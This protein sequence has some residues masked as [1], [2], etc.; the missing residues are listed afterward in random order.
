MLSSFIFCVF[1]AMFFLPCVGLLVVEFP[2]IA[3]YCPLREGR[4][5]SLRTRG[6]SAGLG[7]RAEKVR[8]KPP[9]D[10]SAPERRR[11]SV[12]KDGTNR[13]G[14]RVRAGAKPV[15]HSRT[16]SRPESPPP[17]CLNPQTSTPSVWRA[18]TWAMVRCLRVRPCRTSAYLS[19]TQRDG[20]PLLAGELYRETWAWLDA[21]RGRLVCVS[22]PD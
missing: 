18:V 12:A 9:I 17:A 14:R 22:A 13:G 19:A 3:S 7:C 5:G 15:T 21:R 11:K 20:Q 2:P 6:A 16:S 4:S 10:P 1:T 8:I